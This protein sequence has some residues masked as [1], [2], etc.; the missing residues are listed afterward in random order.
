MAYSY[1]FLSLVLVLTAVVP[2]NAR[3][4]R[5]SQIPN[6][7]V[8]SCGN[9]HVR[10]SGG[11]ARNSFGQTVQS[12]FLTSTGASGSVVWNATLASMDSDGDGF[13]NGEELGDPNGTG[14]PVAGAQVTN[15]GDANSKPQVVQN[16]APVLA[17]IPNAT[18]KEG[19]VVTFFVEATD[20]DNDQITYAAI[21]LPSGG[22]LSDNNF[23]WEPDFEQGGNSFDITFTASDGEE[24]V[25]QT[26]QIVVENVDRK[27]EIASADPGRS[28]VLGM[29]EET[30]TFSID[31][32]DPDGEAVTYVW[33]A[34]GVEQAETGSSFILAVTTGEADDEVS[35]TASSGENSVAQMQWSVAKMLL[36]D[37][38]GDNAVGF[39]DFIEFS[40]VFNKVLGDAEYDP[41]FD[42]SPNDRID[43]FDFLVFIRFFDL[44]V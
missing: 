38:T 5:V 8:N 16:R 19:E 28:T 25:S 9:C 32:E 43:F 37:F 34:N 22:T 12:G 44:S 20:E 33:I 27:V 24:E 41:K 17:S 4:Q 42:L 3:S 6:G 31:A 23:S 14:S 10:S 26:V 35:V 30:I 1:L 13:T 36:G 11:G 15:P 7:N 2:A 21:G 40:L 18:V 29:P 39:F